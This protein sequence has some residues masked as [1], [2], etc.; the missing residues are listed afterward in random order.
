MD[1]NLTGERRPMAVHRLPQRAATRSRDLLRARIAVRP[2]ALTLIATLAAL[3]AIAV[4]LPFFAWPLT[5]DEAGYAY[6]AHWWSQGLTLYSDDLWFD[7]P[8]GIFVAYRIGMFLFGDST[9]AMRL[10]GALWSAA[11]TVFV[12]LLAYRIL[13]LRAAAVAGT[14]VAVLSVAPVIDGFASNAEVF[15][16][17]PAT[18]AA[19]LIWRGRW[20][21][22]GLLVGISILMKPSGGAIL[23]LGL[24]WLFSERAPRRAWIA[25]VS[26]SALP[27][28][29]ALIHGIA[30]VGLHDYLYATVFFRLSTGGEGDPLLQLITGWDK[31]TPV[32]LPLLLLAA[33]GS[34][35]LQSRPSSRKFMS[36]WLAMSMLGVAMG[37]NWFEH[38]FLQIV[39]PLA[40]FAAAALTVPSWI[41]S[42]GRWWSTHLPARL[43]ATTL[44]IVPAL[45]ALVVLIVP[46]AVLPPAEG[47]TRLYDMNGYQQNEEIAAYLAAQTEPTDEIFIAFSH[48]SL[49]YLSGRRSSTPYLYKQ[50]TTEIPG[51]L[52]GQAADVSAGRPALV[53]LIPLQLERYDPEG[54]IR[55]A[56]PAHY[57]YDRSFWSAE[58]WRRR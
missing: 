20:T 39:P 44:A 6:G 17:A 18:G 51:A 30:T 9:E 41:P 58:V 53:F 24:A 54:L 35:A 12:V 40:V 37:G 16:L 33:F 1:S 3:V 19:Y 46:W 21:T 7:R 45:V 13:N 49:L 23:L 34:R 25:F 48:A 55:A 8:Q 42:V 28:A 31:V 43:R 2:N 27:L 26:A 29:I 38:Y 5:V 36:I 4:R 14:L 56:L 15:M 50:Q 22:A 10:H 32:I 57:E 52:E 11:T 47:A